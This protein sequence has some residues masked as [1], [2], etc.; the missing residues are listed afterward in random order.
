MES[1]PRNLEFKNYHESFQPCVQKTGHCHFI[2]LD[3]SLYQLA[4]SALLSALG[5]AL[6]SVSGSLGLLYNLPNSAF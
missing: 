1:Q 4:A 3:C 2:Y 6:L 5:L